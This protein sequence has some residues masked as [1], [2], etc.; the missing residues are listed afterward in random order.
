MQGIINKSIYCVLRS[1]LCRSERA[2]TQ[3]SMYSHQWA[4]YLLRY[5]HPPVLESRQEVHKVQRCRSDF[6]SRRQ[7]RRPQWRSRSRKRSPLLLISSPIRPQQPQPLST[8]LPGSIFSF[9]P[10][11]PRPRFEAESFRKSLEVWCRRKLKK[12]K[13]KNETRSMS[14]VA[15]HIYILRS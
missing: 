7:F 5:T 12:A 11:S 8:R 13:T 4:V 6:G 3:M 15:N 1:K 10:S 9:R 14:P 2:F